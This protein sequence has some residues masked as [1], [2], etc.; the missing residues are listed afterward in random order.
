MDKSLVQADVRGETT[1]YTM[2]ETIREYAGERLA[3][4]EEL[5]GVQAR[6]AH[7]FLSIAEAGEEVWFTAEQHHWL[8]RFDQE[9]YNFQAALAWGRECGQLRP[10]RRSWPGPRFSRPAR[11]VCA[12]RRARPSVPSP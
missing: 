11:T 2:L 10:H 9:R 12:D 8:E 6:H 4:S 5:D 7:Y 1:R 3:E